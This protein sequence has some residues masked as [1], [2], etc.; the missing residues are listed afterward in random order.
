MGKLPSWIAVDPEPV[1]GNYVRVKVYMDVGKGPLWA[2]LTISEA[3]DIISQLSVATK[4][5][6]DAA[7]NGG[8]FSV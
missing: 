4:K 2:L 5:A 1:S 8:L 6:N 7:A 3:L